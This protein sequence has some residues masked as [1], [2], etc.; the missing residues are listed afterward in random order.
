[1]DLILGGYAASRL[2]CMDEDALRLYESLL[3]ENDRE[4]YLWVTGRARPPAPY[5]GLIGDIATYVRSDRR[6]RVR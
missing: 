3:E 4:L 1:M 2:A 5:S 6:G